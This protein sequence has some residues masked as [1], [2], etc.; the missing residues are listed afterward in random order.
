MA[1]TEASHMWIDVAEVA[2]WLNEDIQLK[3]SAT[4]DGRSKSV[5]H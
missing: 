2:H 1:E 5:T 3:R 4:A